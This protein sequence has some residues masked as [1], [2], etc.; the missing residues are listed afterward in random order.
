MAVFAYNRATTFTTDHAQIARIIE[1]FK[2]E[3][4]QIDYEVELQ[5]SGLAAIYG[6]K[7]IPKSLQGKIDKM[8]EG[9][10]LLASQRVDAGA[11]ADKRI[12]KDV[13]R[14]TDAQIQQAGGGVQGK[15]MAEAAGLPYMTAWSDID[16][17]QTQMFADLSLEDF[18]VRHRPDAPGPREHLRRHQLPEALRGREAPRSSS[19][20]RA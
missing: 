10:G 11:A 7:L 6:A 19:P 3:H 1:R 4:E 9:S 17:I 13:Q 14:Q 18:V 16:E 15:A 2:K 8:F 12:E 5:M 20:R